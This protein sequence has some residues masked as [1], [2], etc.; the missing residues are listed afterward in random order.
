[1]ASAASQPTIA[2]RIA[3]RR[4]R[5]KRARVATPK[6]ATWADSDRGSAN[7]LSTEA[8]P[9]APSGGRAGDRPRVTPRARE[10]PPRARSDSPGPPATARRTGFIGGMHG[11]GAPG[12]SVCSP[13]GGTCGRALG[14]RPPRP[15]S[16]HLDG[17]AREARWAPR[18]RSPPPTGEL[19]APPLERRALAGADVVRP[20]LA[21]APASARAWTGG[22]RPRVQANPKHT[23]AHFLCIPRWSHAESLGSN[24]SRADVA[25]GA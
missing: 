6:R 19:L 24:F 5:A 21:R 11:A 4:L 13:S 15:A 7:R 22:A 2:P 3:A 10:T 14:L 8:R 18:P 20:A 16:H 17:S 23:G 1:M 25:E 12:S 9:G